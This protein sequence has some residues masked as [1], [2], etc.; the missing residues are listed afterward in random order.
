MSSSSSTLLSFLNSSI[1]LNSLNK[2]MANSRIARFVTEVAPPQIVSVMRRRAS[3]MLDTINEEERDVSSN[4]SLS[5]SSS[6]GP[7]SASSYNITESK[8]FLKEVQRS[9]SKLISH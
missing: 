6:F 4:D 7:N 1:S 9:I 2:S 8:Y 3:K 5:S